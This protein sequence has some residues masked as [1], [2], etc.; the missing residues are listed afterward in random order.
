MMISSATDQTGHVF[1]TYIVFLIPLA[2]QKQIY[3]VWPITFE[4]A[5]LYTD[6]F[7]VE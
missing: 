7:L 4:A 5:I 6:I 1:D 3:V 2:E